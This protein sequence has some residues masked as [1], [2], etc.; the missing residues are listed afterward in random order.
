[1]R[2]LRGGDGLSDLIGA[3]VRVARNLNTGSW[4]IYTKREGGR[5]RLAA[6]ADSLRL[7]ACTFWVSAATI[8]RIRNGHRELCAYAVGTLQ[9]L[10]ATPTGGARLTFNPYTDDGFKVGGEPAPPTVDGL[11]FTAGGVAEVIS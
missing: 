5:W 6:K 7:T 4:S 3:T 9:A 2:R 8:R 11:T 10:D 1:V